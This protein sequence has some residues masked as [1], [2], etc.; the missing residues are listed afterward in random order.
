MSP[1]LW[2]RRLVISVEWIGQSQ[3]VIDGTTTEVGRIHHKWL[4]IEQ[5]LDRDSKGYYEMR[6]RLG[7]HIVRALSV[8][9][10]TFHS[11]KLSHTNMLTPIRQTNEYEHI[12]IVVSALQ[13]TLQDTL[14]THETHSID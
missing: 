8:I 1:G 4:S 2:C 6:K 5:L 11:S 12:R 3:I 10:S 13:S 14:Q 9:S 7:F